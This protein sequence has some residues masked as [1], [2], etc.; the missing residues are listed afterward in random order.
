M[1]ARTPGEATMAHLKLFIL[2]QPHL[3][4]EGQSIE[5][6]LSKA[7]ALLVDELSG[8]RREHHVRLDAQ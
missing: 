2:D 7:L 4:R 3:K 8:G 1:I 6:N 5:L